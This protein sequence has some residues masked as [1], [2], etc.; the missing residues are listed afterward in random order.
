MSLLMYKTLMYFYVVM[1][2]CV[3]SKFQ[4]EVNSTTVKYEFQ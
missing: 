1:Y 2:M 4:L 3:T